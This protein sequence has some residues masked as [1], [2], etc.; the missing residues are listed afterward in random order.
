M[1]A[2]RFESNANKTLTLRSTRASFSLLTRESWI[3]S[4]RGRPSVGPASATRSIA[5]WTLA[6]RSV[7]RPSCHRANSAVLTRRRSGRGP[8][9]GAKSAIGSTGPA[10]TR[11]PPPRQVTSELKMLQDLLAS[12]IDQSRCGFNV[13]G[14]DRPE[15]ARDRSVHHLDDH[16]RRLLTWVGIGRQ[17]VGEVPDDPREHGSGREQLDHK[18]PDVGFAWA[19]HDSKS[20]Q[21]AKFAP[22]PRQTRSNG[23]SALNDE[24]SDLSEASISSDFQ[25]AGAGFEPATFGL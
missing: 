2:F 13:L 3:V 20:A 18:L 23:V 22:P 15:R 10:I 5:A 6:R 19:L 24:T 16:V 25:V 12:E 11:V 17:R 21:R 7:S 4:T 9:R 1:T 8:G 14:I